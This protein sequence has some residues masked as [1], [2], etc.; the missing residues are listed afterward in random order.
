[1]RSE[2]RTRR[3]SV[4]EDEMGVLYLMQRREGGPIKLGI[5][6][7]YNLESRRKKNEE[8][9]RCKLNVLDTMPGTRRDERRLHTKLNGYRLPYTPDRGGEW[10]Y[11]VYEVH[12][13]F[14]KERR[15]RRQQRQ[16][17]HR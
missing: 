10:F 16:A 14:V 13:I 3:L 5:A 8:R 6:R 9:F 17:K 2:E 1:M 12:D 4:D 11:D 15:R 7:K